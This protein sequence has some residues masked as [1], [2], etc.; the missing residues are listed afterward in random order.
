MAFYSAKCLYTVLEKKGEILY[1]NIIKSWYNYRQR[2]HNM[3]G[4]VYQGYH[5]TTKENA[6]NII[7]GGFHMPE[8]EDKR[9]WAYW[10][11]A[12]V[13]FFEDKDV[14][15]WWSSKPSKTFGADGEHVVLKSEIHPNNIFDIR[16]VSSW[17]QLV[18]S[19]D[20]FMKTLSNDC[21]VNDKKDNNTKKR[22]RCLFFNWFWKYYHLDM[23]I[24]AFNQS[25]FDYL[26]AGEYSIEKEMDIYYTEVQ[27][28]IY[29][30]AIINNTIKI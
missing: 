28:C 11:G 19:F 15:E 22:L 6:V 2:G 21:I 30:T 26:D 7:F 3:E 14:A 4:N 17:N 5:S 9:F 8:N 23:I 10:L 12:G 16:K 27:Y 20:Y 29:D 1:N 24:A 18:K 13:Y 25:E